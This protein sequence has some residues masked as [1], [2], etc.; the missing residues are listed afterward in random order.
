V[1][2]P[3]THL[4]L[5]AELADSSDVDSDWKDTTWRTIPSLRRGLPTIDHLFRTS[6]FGLNAIEIEAK[7]IGQLLMDEVLHP[8]YIF[9]IFSIILWSID[10][11]YCTY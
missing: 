6:L 4:S 11:Y 2:L 8:F 9:Q 10:D 3:H 7:T 1:S 5:S